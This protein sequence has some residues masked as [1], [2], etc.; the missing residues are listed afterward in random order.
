M[1]SMWKLY[2]ALLVITAADGGLTTIFSPFLEHSKFAYDQIGLIVALLGIT[3]LIAR[4]PAGVLYGRAGVKFLLAGF[5]LLFIVSTA[6]FAYDGGSRYILFWTIW[7]GFAFG[8]IGTIMLAWA[9][10]LNSTS[11]S[12]GAAMGWYT[13]ALSAGYSIGSFFGGYFADTLG[14]SPTFVIMGVLPLISLSLMLTMATPLRVGAPQLPANRSNSARGR[15][16]WTQWTSAL[17]PNLML[18]TLIAFYL[19]FLDDGFGAFF[20]LFGLS[21][22]LNLTFVGLLKSIRSLTATGLRPFAGVIFKH[23]PM[24]L[25]NNVLLVAWAA[26][27]FV[28][29]DLHEPWILILLF[30]LIGVCRGLTRVASAT[31]IAEERSKNTGGIGVASGLYN[32]GLDIGAF[33]G[34]LV[35]G[36]IASASDITTMFRI[37]PTALLVVYLAATL[38][39]TR[40]QARQAVISNR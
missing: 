28:I 35:G 39:V 8:G 33:L 4:L 15:E 5:L 27:V 3:Q 34:P 25:L 1:R 24:G 31:M 19:N 23:V 30:I 36:W 29:P 9:I 12:Q 14:F 16:R 38:A 21:I 17:T 40:V 22:G 18:A 13:A 11:A 2:L 6:A 26:A 32:A 10:E 37:A 7:R 20:P